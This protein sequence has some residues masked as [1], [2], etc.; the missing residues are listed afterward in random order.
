LSRPI[1]NYRQTGIFG[2]SISV[3]FNASIIE[4]DESYNQLPF[5]PDFKFLNIQKAERLVAMGLM[6][7][8]T[9]KD[10]DP[11]PDG[12]PPVVPTPLV[13]SEP[14]P[15]PDPDGLPPVCPVSTHA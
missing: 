5:P 2:C 8:P 7:T 10:A 14:E 1:R 6:P 3:D 13:P 12:L 9:P 4:G 11:D 15:D